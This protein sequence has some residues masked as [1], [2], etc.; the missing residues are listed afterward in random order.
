M[1]MNKNRVK[2]KF[3]KPFTGI[4]PGDPPLADWKSYRKGAIFCVSE[5]M[6]DIL[7]QEDLVQ[8]EN[9]KPNRAPQAGGASC[10]PLASADNPPHASDPPV[11][12]GLTP[13]PIAKCKKEPTQSRTLSE[14]IIYQWK[15]DQAIQQEFSFL[16]S[17][18][19]YREADASGRVKIYGHARGIKESESVTEPQR[20]SLPPEGQAKAEWFSDPSLHEEFSSFENYLAYRKAEAQGL[21]RV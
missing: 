9:S 6:A 7:I 14:D 15:N 5:Q 13:S 1:F 21:V 4:L 20:S 2:I 16:G 10:L 3:T 11:L 17:Y 19:A 18:A 8:L 12:R